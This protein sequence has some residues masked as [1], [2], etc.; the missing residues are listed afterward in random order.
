[1]T[2]WDE[3]ALKKPPWTAITIAKVF[4]G[5]TLIGYYWAAVRQSSSPVALSS[6][7]DPTEKAVAEKTKFL[8]W[9]GVLPWYI[10][11][12]VNKN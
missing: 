2:S 7:D 5:L 3:L 10:I 8:R 6:K 11:E 1:M 4:F 9:S 12:S